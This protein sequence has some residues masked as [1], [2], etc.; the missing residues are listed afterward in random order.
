[1]TLKN[2][3]VSGMLVYDIILNDQRVIL[4]NKDGNS[5][6]KLETE[7][8]GNLWFSFFIGSLN[9]SQNSNCLSDK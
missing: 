2:A 4:Y 1:V 8:W 7:P 3:L 6:I 9:Q 5:Q